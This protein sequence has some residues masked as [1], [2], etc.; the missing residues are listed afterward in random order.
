MSSPAQRRNGRPHDGISAL[1]VAD[2]AQRR[3]E[4]RRAEPRREGVE[5]CGAARADRDPGAARA[6]GHGRSG[7]DA[8]GAARHQDIFSREIEHAI[9]SFHRPGRRCRS[10]GAVVDCRR[11]ALGGHPKAARYCR[12]KYSGEGKPQAKAI[13]VTPSSVCC[14]S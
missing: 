1:P 14:S 6:E 13:S 2:I 12:E 3:H 9:G 5:G 7:A 8:A 4:A 11:S 10:T